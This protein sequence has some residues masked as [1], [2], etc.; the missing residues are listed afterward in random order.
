MAP[1]CGAILIRDD[2]KSAEET[3]LAPFDL[4]EQVPARRKIV[5]MGGIEEPLPP[6]RAC[7]RR[8]G[9]RLSACADRAY[10]V[11]RHAP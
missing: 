2:W 8:V 9:E 4:L 7:Y 5:L 1:S 6:V 3:M 10:I 11:G